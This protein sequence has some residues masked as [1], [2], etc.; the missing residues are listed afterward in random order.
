MLAA[1]MVDLNMVDLN[2]ADLNGEE[3]LS[4]VMVVEEA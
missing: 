2:T 1:R 3:N 4:L